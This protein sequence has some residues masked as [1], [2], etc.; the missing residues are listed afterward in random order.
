MGRLACLLIVVKP[1]ILV[2]VVGL[3][4]FAVYVALIVV[5]GLLILFGDV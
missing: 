1:L 2:L 5:I 3:I 4:A